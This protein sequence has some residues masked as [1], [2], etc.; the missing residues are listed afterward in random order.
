MSNTSKVT[1]QEL[2]LLFH[3]K[4]LESNLLIKKGKETFNITDI[5]YTTKKGIQ[6]VSNTNSDDCV[7]VEELLKILHYYNLNSFV[8]CSFNDQDFE[9][10]AIGN[11]SKNI[12]FI[13]IQ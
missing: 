9:I 1:V 2:I 11:T 3:G 12:S 6:I 5:R 8:T 7:K 10:I 13:E 4:R